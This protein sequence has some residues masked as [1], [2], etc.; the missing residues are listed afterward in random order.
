MMRAPRRRSR[1]TTP[2]STDAGSG[3]IVRRRKSVLLDPQG[4]RDLMVAVQT[5]VQAGLAT[6]VVVVVIGLRRATMARVDDLAVRVPD[7]MRVRGAMPVRDVMRVPDAMPVPGAMRVLGEI[8]V[9]TTG[10][11]V[12]IAIVDVVA[13]PRK[14]TRARVAVVVAEVVVVVAV[15]KITTIPRRPAAARST[16]SKTGIRPL[17]HEPI[18]VALVGQQVG[19]ASAWANDGPA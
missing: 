6:S 17:A 16:I 9:G 4:V 19:D 10:V 11:V 5:G 3:S 13:H 2:R 12:A 15:V 18:G 1:S 8:S 14:R 7:A